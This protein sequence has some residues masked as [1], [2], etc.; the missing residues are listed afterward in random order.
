MRPVSDRFLRTVITSH[1][2]AVEVIVCTPGVFQTGVN[3]TG[4]VLELLSGDVKLVGAQDVRS[5]IDCE[6]HGAGWEPKPGQLITPYG[7]E[8][9]A[10]RA[11]EYGNGEREW[12]SLGYF[13]MN[14]TDQS[15]TTDSPIRISGSDRMVGIVESELLS[16]VSFP[17]SAT[18]ADAFSALVLEVYPTASIEYDFVAAT[19]QLGR[20]HFADEDRYQFLFDLANSRGKIMYF[21]YRGV[22]VVKSPPDPTVPV[23]EVGAGTGGILISLARSINREGVFNAVIATGDA[24][25]TN[26]PVR[27]VAR[28]M[29]PTSPTY[30]DGPFGKIPK[31]LST[32]FITNTTNAADAA[33]AELLKVVGLP[34]SADFS[35]VPNPALEPYDPINVKTDAGIETHV[36]DTLTIPLTASAPMTGTTRELTSHNIVVQVS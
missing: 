19:D 11:V 5:T 4:T 7:N 23:F 18:F 17:A 14:A 13:R 20:A 33:S 27:A 24:P 3:P 29:E 16:P 34:Y 1:A 35:A 28:D 2:I 10:R 22:L 6:V 12:V 25:D 31:R 26:A 15:P 8:L 30:W 9:F 21:D 32:P 36:L